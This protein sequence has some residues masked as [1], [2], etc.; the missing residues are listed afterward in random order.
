MDA[1]SIHLEAIERARHG[2]R[3]GTL[4]MVQLLLSIFKQAADEGII[5]RLEQIRDRLVQDDVF[6]FDIREALEQLYDF[7]V[8]RACA[9]EVLQFVAGVQPR[10]VA[11]PE[12]VFQVSLN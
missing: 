9:V 4:E 7:I 3:A 12:Q 8:A 10:K 6:L 2:D 1:P 11:P 5:H